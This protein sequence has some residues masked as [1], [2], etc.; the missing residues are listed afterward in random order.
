M[1]V[2]GN[3]Y[4]ISQV[5]TEQ[6]SSKSSYETSGTFRDKKHEHA[7][8]S[9]S[10]SLVEASL[11]ADGTNELINDGDQT[12]VAGRFHGSHGSKLKANKTSMLAMEMNNYQL[13]A[14]YDENA[15]TNKMENKGF[16]S[17]SYAHSSISGNGPKSV[18][19]NEI[20]IDF[21]QERNLKAGQGFSLNI[22]NTDHKPEWARSLDADGRVKWNPV[23]EK[24]ESWDKSKTV[25]NQE[26][27][28]FISAAAGLATIWAG[29]VGSIGSGAWGKAA[30]AAGSMSVSMI[31][32][33][34]DLGKSLED[35]FSKDGL[36]PIAIIN[37]VV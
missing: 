37:A 23:H 2:D 16:D 11:S 18:E 15:F 26:T 21:T 25:L 34:G 13:D 14:S 7:H 10:E 36:I 17:L 9:R 8:Q 28:T 32:N 5:A 30:T 6:E 35:T 31:N 3:S 22:T 12:F 1:K 19:S 33:Q 24:S 27:A 29:G 4:V 20:E